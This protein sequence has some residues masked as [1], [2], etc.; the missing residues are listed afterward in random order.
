MTFF[1]VFAAQF[2][3]SQNKV[4]GKVV[5]ELG[6]PLYKA[7]ISIADSEDITYTDFDGKFTLESAKKFHWKVLIESQGF[8]PE[9][10]FV[11]DG[12]SMETLHLRFDLDLGE[13][14][15]DEEKPIEKEKPK[16]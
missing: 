11:L 13:L 15:A 16:R 6:F 14:I 2:C 3:F 7:S 12:G 5:D 8:E 1:L 10:F 9:T 4:T